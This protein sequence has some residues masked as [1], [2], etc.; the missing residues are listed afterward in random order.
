MSMPVAMPM[1]ASMKAR[2]SVDAL[3]LAPGACGQPPMPAS[4]RVEAG[5][6]DFERRVDVGQREAARVVEVAAPEAVAG[7]A[8]APARTGRAPCAG[9]A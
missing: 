3:P 7:D 2:S 9:S 5:D 4:V 6:A 1:L 8:A